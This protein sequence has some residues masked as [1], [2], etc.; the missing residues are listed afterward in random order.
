MK[1]IIFFLKVTA[2]MKHF[3]S[4]VLKRQTQKFED[5]S[6]PWSTLKGLSIALALVFNYSYFFE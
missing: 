3:R 5:Q 1:G 2:K 4:L 6:E